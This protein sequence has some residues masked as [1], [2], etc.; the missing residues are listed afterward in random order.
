M[1]FFNNKNFKRIAA[2]VILAV[3]AAMLI[4]MVVPYLA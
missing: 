2:I 1:N 3:I 4:T